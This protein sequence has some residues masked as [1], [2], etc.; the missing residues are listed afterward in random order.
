MSKYDWEAHNL[1]LIR[2]RGG[3]PI[4][5]SMMDMVAEIFNL[6]KSPRALEVRH[7]WTAIS[8]VIDPDHGLGI[9]RMTAGDALAEKSHHTAST[10]S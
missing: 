8:N 7:L 4:Y 6:Y 9:S 10:H 2:F 1:D 5:F 3:P